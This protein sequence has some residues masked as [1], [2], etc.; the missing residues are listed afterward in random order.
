MPVNILVTFLLGSALGWIIIKLTKPPRHIE[1]LIVGVCSAGRYIS[2]LHKKNMSMNIEPGSMSLLKVSGSIF[3][4]IF[5][6]AAF[7][8]L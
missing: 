6:I 1:G 7:M 4:L 8:K 2:S 5:C 3:I